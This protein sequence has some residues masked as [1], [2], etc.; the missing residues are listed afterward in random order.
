MS[1]LKNV[2]YQ[3]DRCYYVPEDHII[4]L[5]EITSIVILFILL[6]G[7]G[8]GEGV[9]NTDSWFGKQILYYFKTRDYKNIF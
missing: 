9:I 4:L 6:V 3:N 8:G 1:F 5:D 2:V 7:G